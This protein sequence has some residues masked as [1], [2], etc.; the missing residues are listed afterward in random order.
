MTQSVNGA[1]AVF[2]LEKP[3]ILEVLFY[4][5]D[6]TSHRVERYALFQPE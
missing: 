1:N 3:C 5:K 2:L 6:P 4:A